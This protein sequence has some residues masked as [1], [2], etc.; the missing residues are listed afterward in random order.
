[1]AELKKVGGRLKKICY[2]WM[3]PALTRY[4]WELSFK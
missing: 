4:C 2:V 3:V 1:M